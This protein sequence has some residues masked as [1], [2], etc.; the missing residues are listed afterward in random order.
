[1][2]H[3]VQFALRC[4]CDYGS[5]INVGLSQLDALLVNFCQCGTVCQCVPLRQGMAWRHGVGVM[6]VLVRTWER[7]KVGAHTCWK[8]QIPGLIRTWQKREHVRGTPARE[9]ADRTVPN[10]R[11]ENWSEDRKKESHSPVGE[12]RQRDLSGQSRSRGMLIFLPDLTRLRI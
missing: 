5:S 12:G 3:Q 1:M 2:L 7:S 11:G 4:A 6:V 9:D 10:S 8:G